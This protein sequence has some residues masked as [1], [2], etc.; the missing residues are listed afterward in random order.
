MTPKFGAY[1]TIVIYDHK[2]L[3]VQAKGFEVSPKTK[4]SCLLFWGK[5]D[6]ESDFISLIPDWN[7]SKGGSRTE[8]HGY[9]SSEREGNGKFI[10]SYLKRKDQYH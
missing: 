2:T 4:N 1:L 6:K 10:E 7:A 8:R 5:S 9:H 3:I